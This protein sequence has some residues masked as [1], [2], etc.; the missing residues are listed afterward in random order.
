MIQLYGTPR[1]SAGRVYWLLEE[2]GLPYEV[3]GLDL[4]TGENE[5]PEYLRLNPNGAVPTLID[6]SNTIWE[7]AAINLYLADK[8]RPELIGATPEERALVYQWS[9]WSMVT[10][11]PPL[12]ELFIQKVFV[13]EGS[14]DAK[15]ISESEGALPE[16]FEIV[17][18]ALR[19][20]EYLA[21]ERFTLADLQVASVATIA[22]S[23]ELDISKYSNMTRWLDQLRERPAW[24]KLRE[25]R[26]ENR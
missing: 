11:Q 24:R 15:I 23:L 9:V 22:R 10:F 2:L 12:I 19:G 16:L 5:S 13:P 4:R 6:G 1:T 18:N 20:K 14:R 21:H 7:S 3:K 8:Y 17:D 25:L 26:G